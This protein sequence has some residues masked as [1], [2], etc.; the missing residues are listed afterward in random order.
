MDPN[1]PGTWLLPA[2]GTQS[3]SWSIP[4]PYD[5][6]ASHRVSPGDW[7]A[8]LEF[9]EQREVAVPSQERFSSMGDT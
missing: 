4:S 3:P 9:R 7:I 5:F 8:R 1:A 6:Y 2:R